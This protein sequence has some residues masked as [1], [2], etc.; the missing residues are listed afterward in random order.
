MDS[1][2][3]G[4]TEEGD[5][6]PTVVNRTVAYIALVCLALLVFL[7]I[8]GI[9]SMTRSHDAVFYSI[10]VKHFPA[11]IGLPISALAALVLVFVLEYA[12]GPI[13]FQGFGFKFKGAA[14]PIAFWMAC[15]LVINLSI[16]SLWG[17]EFQSPIAER[18]LEGLYSYQV[19]TARFDGEVQRC[20][21]DALRR[22]QKV[23]EREVKNVCTSRILDTFKWD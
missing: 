9:V 13:E 4:I 11:T 15:F 18:V 12:K 16:Y 19:K 20:V 5:R 6:A 3:K 14:A 2:N 7:L 23:A 21:Q 10:L 22:D 17:R 1:G 8:A